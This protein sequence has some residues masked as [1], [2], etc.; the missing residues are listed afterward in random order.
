MVLA[1]INRYAD[2]IFGVVVVV[3]VVL[4]VVVVCCDVAG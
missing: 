4:V 2:A 1:V 3:L